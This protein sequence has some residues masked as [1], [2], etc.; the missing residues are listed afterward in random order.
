MRI[1]DLGLIMLYIFHGD[2]T[3]KSRQ[4][5][6][7]ALSKD[8]A[9]GIEIRTLEGDKISARDLDS[10][11]STASL[12]STESIA[13]EGLLCRLRSKEKD[14]C[15]EIVSK[16]TG[17]KNIYLWDK[18]EITAPNLKKFVGAKISVSKAPTVLFDFLDS[19]IPGNFTRSIDLL[20]ELVKGTEDIVA[21]TMLSRQIGYLIIIKSATNPKFA[22]WQVGKLRSQAS[23]WTDPQLSTFISDLL[24]IDLSIKTGTSKLSYTDHL[25]ILLSTLLR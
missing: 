3:A 25:D 17:D 19:I 24:K 15:I 7:D 10:I 1:Y 9:H 2:G 4:L 21:F 14:L 13:I 8:K 23:K 22:P 18:K 12:F 16:Y 11:L 5:F 20:H 6:Q